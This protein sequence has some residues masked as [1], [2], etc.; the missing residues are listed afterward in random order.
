MATGKVLGSAHIHEFDAAVVQRLCLLVIDRGGASY[1]VVSAALAQQQA[2]FL[3][4]Y[5]DSRALR[6]TSLAQALDQ[7]VAVCRIVVKEVAV[8]P[9][10]PDIWTVMVL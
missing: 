1:V 8:P 5:I 3:E 10:A 4:G 9:P 6:N 7:P 2:V